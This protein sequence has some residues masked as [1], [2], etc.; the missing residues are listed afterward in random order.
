MGGAA[1]DAA[2]EPDGAGVGG[3]DGHYWCHPVCLAQTGQSSGAVG[4]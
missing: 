3:S 4:Y 1:D 2:L